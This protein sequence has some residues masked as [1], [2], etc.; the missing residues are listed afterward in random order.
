MSKAFDTISHSI[1]LHKLVHQFNFNISAV[2]FVS[3]YFSNRTQ[4]VKVGD[5]H[6]NPLV[7]PNRGVPQGS[8][9]GPLLFIMMMND[10]SKLQLHGQLCVYICR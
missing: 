8:I 7:I 1:L 2:E 5:T 10:I 4:I 9:L 6:T 3:S